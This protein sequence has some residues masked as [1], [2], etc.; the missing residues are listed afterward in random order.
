[1]RNRAKN[2]AYSLKKISQTMEENDI[3]IESHYYSN[4]G[5][6]NASQ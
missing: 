6:N 4:Y 5:S 2:R 3:I 1:M